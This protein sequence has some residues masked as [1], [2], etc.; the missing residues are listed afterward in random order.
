M[1]TEIKTEGAVDTTNHEAEGGSENENDFIKV[2]KA[3]YEKTNQTLGSLKREL[4][5]L[6]KPKETQETVQTKPENGL[7]EKAYLR[8]AQITDPEEVELALNTSKKWG[9]TID[10]LVEDDDFK[11]KLEKVRT[12]KSNER[13]TSGVKGGS[14]GTQLKADPAYWKA[15]GQPPTPADIPDRKTRAKIIREMISTEKSGGKK[16]WND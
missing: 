16:F 6:K 3:E 1:E 8:T 13:A 12:Q 9:L 15:K 5:D 14:G 10:Q 4:K 2:P 11:I 7:L